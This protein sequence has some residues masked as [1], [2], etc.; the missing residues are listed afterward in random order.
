MLDI[1]VNNIKVT[2]DIL[3]MYFSAFIF[4]KKICKIPF[5]TLPP[6]NGYIGIKLNKINI[7]LEYIIV[8]TENTFRFKHSVT[9]I[10]IKLVNGPTYCN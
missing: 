7:K 2:K 8:S 3:F 5:N 1:K 9:I 6:S 10:I 4:P